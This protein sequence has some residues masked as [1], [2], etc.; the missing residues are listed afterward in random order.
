MIR[1][2]SKGEKRGRIALPP[3]ILP[4][5]RPLRPFF[6]HRPASSGEGQGGYPG[7][8][9]MLTSGGVWSTMKA[10]SRAIAAASASSFAGRSCSGI[11]DH[12]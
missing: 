5:E 8:P 3:G 7:R 9:A 2:G 6:G 4:P 11:T 10:I 12:V 1:R